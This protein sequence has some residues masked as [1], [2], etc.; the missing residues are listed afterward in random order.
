MK[1]CKSIRNGVLQSAFPDTDVGSIEG[2]FA[3]D[4]H[5]PNQP[6]QEYRGEFRF[7]NTPPQKLAAMLETVT[8]EDR[9]ALELALSMW[10]SR[11]ADIKA[12]EPDRGDVRQVERVTNMRDLTKRMNPVEH[13]RVR[14]VMSIPDAS[15]GIIDFDNL[16][17]D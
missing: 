16:K 10:R 7:V 12:G 2:E 1:V 14:G 4:I 17:E 13:V 5:E 3:P 15:G 8:D 9:E 6:D 11:A